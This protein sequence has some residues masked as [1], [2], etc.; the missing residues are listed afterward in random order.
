MAARVRIEPR[1]GAGSVQADLVDVS[2]GG[3]RASCALA[4][5][6]VAGGEVDIEITVQD[7]NDARHPP[8][9]NLRGQGELV[10]VHTHGGRCDMA[11]RFT[12][13]LTLRE[14]FSQMLLF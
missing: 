13:A 14:P 3:L 1:V 12:G 5:E 9:V 7:A 11:V 10:R 2:A 4:T 6:L 8:L